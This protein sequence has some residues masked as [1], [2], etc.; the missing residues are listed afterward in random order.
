[1]RTA[2]AVAVSERSMNEEVRPPAGATDG[3]ERPIPRVRGLSLELEVPLLITAL[4]GAP[5]HPGPPRDA[6]MRAA[7]AVAFSE[8]SM[9]E[10][11]R[12]PAGA[13]DGLERPIPR[14]RGLALELKVPLLSTALLVVLLSVTVALSYREIEASAL[15][16]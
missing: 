1:M 7:P 9:N 13:T 5:H 8:R 3:L 4:P 11:V 2:P 16:A 10:E 12:H 6:W 15:T 14:V